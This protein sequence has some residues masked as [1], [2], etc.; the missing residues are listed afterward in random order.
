LASQR[1]AGGGIVVRLYIDYVVLCLG[2]GFASRRS[3]AR[4][5]LAARWFLFGVLYWVLSARRRRRRHRRIRLLHPSFVL[6]T[7]RSSANGEV[8]EICVGV[9]G[10][11]IFIFAW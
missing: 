3:A 6:A 10:R 9:R 11:H 4:L 1:E 8:W 5:G 2:L 7:L